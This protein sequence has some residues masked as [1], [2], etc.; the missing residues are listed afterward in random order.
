MRESGKR[1]WPASWPPF[2][3][4]MLH[5]AIA[6]A[7]GNVALGAYIA[8]DV[9]HGWLSLLFGLSMSIVACEMTIVLTVLTCARLARADRHTTLS[10]LVSYFVGVLAVSS[11]GLGLRKWP[12]AED[13]VHVALAAAVGF[14][15]MGV[16]FAFFNP[17]VSRRRV[18]AVVALGTVLAWLAFAWTVPYFGVLVGA[19]LSYEL[20]YLSGSSVTYLGSTCRVLLTFPG[21]LVG[22]PFAFAVTAAML[23]RACEKPRSGADGEAARR[24]QKAFR[25]RLLPGIAAALAVMAVVVL[26]ATIPGRLR[27][28]HLMKAIE[29]G[30]LA[31][32]KR[33]VDSGVSLSALDILGQT[34]LYVAVQ[35]GHVDIAGL[36]LDRGASIDDGDKWGR[37]PMDGAIFSGRKE[38][39]ALLI[40]RGARLALWNGSTLLHDAARVGHVEIVQLLID[41]GA[42]LD[43]KDSFRYTPLHW[44]ALINHVEIARILLDRGADPNA[45]GS[46]GDTPLQFAAQHGH[47]KTAEL[48]LFCG[49]DANTTNRAGRTP[50]DTA[51]LHAR[52][53][54]VDLLRAHGG[55]TA[56]E[57]RAGKGE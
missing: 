27:L 10:L 33:L 37:S 14:P 13:W 55:K 25:G 54:L 4:A 11:V 23:V 17:H 28:H 48:L 20:S 30:E 47:A 3:R 5:V 51:R 41:K 19:N 44:A 24:A 38:V 16:L 42:E 57:L 40:A 18:L 31:E 34:P 9:C 6:T 50:L 49:A 36:L 39:V 35:S 2:Y 7:V 15:V 52:L 45:K 53:K 56:K 32:V 22:F 43:L 46:D 1:P 21:G 26:G 12:V 8:V 29:S